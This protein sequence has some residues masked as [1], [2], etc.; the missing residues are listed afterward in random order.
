MRFFMEH[1][2]GF[3]AS[4]LRFKVLEIILPDRMNFER[5]PCP[6][7]GMLG[8]FIWLQS[9]QQPAKGLCG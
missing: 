7:V 8:C 3:I 6:G 4:R 2:F 5:C 1:V 9:S